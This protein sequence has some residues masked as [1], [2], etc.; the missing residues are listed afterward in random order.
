M[1]TI[2]NDWLKRQEEYERQ[3]QEETERW[4]KET[5]EQTKKEIAESWEKWE[6]DTESK[7]DFCSNDKCGLE[8]DE[9]YLKKFRDG[10]KYCP[11]CYFKLTK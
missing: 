10:K 2:H 5:T 8:R 6:K 1:N 11:H 4:F 3:R 9:F 7:K